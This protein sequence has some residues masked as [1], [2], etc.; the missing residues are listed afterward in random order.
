MADPRDKFQGEGGFV[1]RTLE[2][3][4]PDVVSKAVT[5]GIRSFLST[6]DGLRRAADGIPSEVVRFLATQLDGIRGDVFKIVKSELREF[7]DRVNVGQEAARVLT[8]LTLQVT[9]EIRFL[10]NDKVGLRPS[11]KAKVRPRRASEN[12]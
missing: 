2:R 3:I 4:L 6:H 5:T 11:V 7:L 8:A 9:M 12:K 1:E 10:P